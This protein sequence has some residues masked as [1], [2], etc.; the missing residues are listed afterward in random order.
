[1]KDLV[2]PETESKNEQRRNNDITDEGYA[3]S[4]HFLFVTL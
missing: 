2:I 4:Q 3:P 1:M